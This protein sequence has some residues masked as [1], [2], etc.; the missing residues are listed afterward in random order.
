MS[1]ASVPREVPSLPS[2][3]SLH[4]VPSGSVPRLP[5]YYPRTPTSRAP[6]RVAS[7]PSLRDTSCGASFAPSAA[8]PPLSA[9][10]TSSTPPAASASTRRARELPG[11]WRTPSSDR[12]RSWTPADRCT[13]PSRFSAVALR[14]EDS[15]GSANNPPFGA[16]SHRLSDPLCTLRSRDRSRTTQHSVS[17]GGQP[18]PRRVFHPS[19]PI[20][21]FPSCSWSLHSFL[22]LQASP[23]ATSAEGPPFVSPPMESSTKSSCR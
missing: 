1:C 13:R 19:G 18:L 12:R 23:G 22:L 17:A 9:W 10:A 7:L 15:S 21:R 5:R 14:S 3:A 20:R 4:R 16:R 8:A 11:S 6:S 2:A